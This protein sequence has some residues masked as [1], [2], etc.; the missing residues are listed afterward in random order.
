MPSFSTGLP[1]FIPMPIAS[2]KALIT[3]T[4][5]MINDNLSYSDY[6]VNVPIDNTGAYHDSQSSYFSDFI[7]GVDDYV[8]TFDTQLPEVLYSTLSTGTCSASVT[9]V[10]S[11]YLDDQIPEVLESNM[12]TSTCSATI[13]NITEVDHNTQLPETL[14]SNMTTGICSATI[15]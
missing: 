3:E 7:I 8:V 11:I 4:Y 12:I 1:Y 2:D 13:I 5:V 9:T 6:S 10:E 15:T 14:Q